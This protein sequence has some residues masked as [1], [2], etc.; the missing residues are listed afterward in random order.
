[1]HRV[2]VVQAA[3]S[4]L[5]TDDTNII[6]SFIKVNA[7]RDNICFCDSPEQADFIVLFQE[8]SFKQRGYVK[9]LLEDRIF[10]KYFNKIYV[11][12][13]DSTVGEGF[14][15]GC[16][17]SL[18]QSSTYDPNRFIASAYPKT[19]NEFLAHPDSITSVERNYLYW[20]RGTLHSYP[21]RVKL[22][23]EL[24]QSKHG[25]LVDVTK[26]F[27]THTENEKQ[28]YVNE[29][30]K[31]KF[32]LCPRGT[33]P[34][35]YR[36][37]EAMSVGR[38]PVI[39]SDDWVETDGP[40]WQQCSIRVPEKNIKNIEAILLERESEAFDLGDNARKEWGRYFSIEA[41]YKNYAD[42]I[43]QLHQSAPSV[44]FSIEDYKKHWRSN[45]FLTNNEWAL[46]QRVNRLIKKCLKKVKVIS[47]N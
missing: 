33:S 30:L 13:Y 22:F 4:Q 2:F 40:D 45:V 1:M 12:N 38:C 36:L 11:V 39:I 14:L 16:Y 44:T 28:S 8:W 10:K 37:F 9:E 6:E 35:S 23:N 20:F 43:I 21:T 17:V 47:D 3:Q 7:Q 24:S 18:R 27:H 41:K 46:V 15:P 42:Q 19:Y 32:V 25:L 34:N 31:S 5:V 29:M 26:A